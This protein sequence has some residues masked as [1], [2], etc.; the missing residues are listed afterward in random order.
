[1]SKN[2]SLLGELWDFLRVRK[3][4]WLA[5]I[6]IMLILVGA[7][8]MS[9]RDDSGLRLPPSVAPFQIVIVPISLGN[10]I[11]EVLPLAKDIEKGLLEL[12]LRVKLDE[13]EEFTPGWKFSEWEMRG[14]PL[15]VEIG[16]KDI[17]KKQVVIVRRDTGEK[18]N[19]AQASMIKKVPEILKEIQK[20]MFE[21]ALKFQQENTHEVKDYEEFKAV[22]KSK[23]GFIKAFWCES[24]DCEEK[25]KEETLASIRVI[26]LDQDKKAAR[27]KCVSCQNPAGTVVY[28]GKAY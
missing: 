5:P 8:I 22:M 28:F 1:M 19:L 17:E 26:L 14:V 4:W 6:I 10:W 16:P 12:G 13:R 2:K 7:L 23:K 18:E 21:M 3:A 25:I 27:G 20:N 9:H 24:Q 15:R 11:K